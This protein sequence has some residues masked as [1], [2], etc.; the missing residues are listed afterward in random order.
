MPTV[1]GP[2]V[3]RFDASRKSMRFSGPLA[4]RELVPISLSP[5]AMAAGESVLTVERHGVELAETTLTNGEGT[6][7]LST[8]E[9]VAMFASL[10]SRARLTCSVHLWHVAE[11]RLLASGT[12]MLVNN[13]EALRSTLRM[14]AAGEL[15]MVLAEALDAGKPVKRDAAG[16]AAGVQ[17]GEGHLYL[18]IVAESGLAGASV[19]VV[20]AGIA[21]VAGWGLAPGNRYYLAHGAVGLTTTA[22]AGYNELPVGIA[23]DAAT[24]VLANQPVVQSLADS[25]VV[26]TLKWDTATRR[27]L[28]VAA[29][30]TSA[31]AASAG[32]IPYLGVDGKI[33]TTMLPD[34]LLQWHNL[35]AGVSDLP[36]D[37]TVGEVIAKL[38]EILTTLKGG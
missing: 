6:L 21:A 20:T 7:D 27:F 28:A 14:A 5:A 29:V 8:Q 9:A 3:V 25:D 24:L 26:H 19:R 30:A 10:P 37:P 13:P 33:S 18:G 17:A 16:K 11:D 35:F 31:G 22:P 34:Y 15:R 2:V 38:S 23:L 4:V 1:I 36:A 32:L 12:V